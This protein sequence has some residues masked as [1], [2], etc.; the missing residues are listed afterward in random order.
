MLAT[1]LGRQV[2]PIGVRMYA[3]G[4]K[5][6][7]HESRRYLVWRC[8]KLSKGGL[9]GSSV[10]GFRI[11]RPRITPLIYR[12]DRRCFI[13]TGNYN[14]N[15][16]AA[17]VTVLPRNLGGEPHDEFDVTHNQVVKYDFEVWRPRIDIRESPCCA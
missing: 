2:L 16:P 7:Q 1:G 13:K 11:R 14:G 3:E 12:F 4:S 9:G 6:P 5:Q 8:I 17:V 15:L 10:C